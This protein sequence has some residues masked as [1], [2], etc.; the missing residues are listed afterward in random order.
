MKAGAS[1]RY[2]APSLAVLA[3]GAMLL[4]AATD[5]FEALTEE[6]ARRLHIARA[7]PAVPAFI[8]QDQ[9]GE[10]VRIGGAPVERQPIVLAEFIYTSCPTICQAAGSHY[11]RL[12]DRLA[13]AG[14][15]GRVKL[16]SI[17]FDPLQDDPDELWAYA[18]RHGA[19]GAIWRIARL[20][21][22]DVGTA[23]DAFG[24]RIIADSWGGYQHNAAIHLIDASGRL[25]RIF[26]IGDIEEAFRAVECQL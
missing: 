14:Y 25:S 1:I 23:A 13:Q 22:A 18:D 4:W 5:G 24:I 21:P 11:A 6:G 26:D 12:R 16:L 20:Q 19:D 7:Q 17:S 15:G 8:L 9:Y 3:A 10:A 2:F